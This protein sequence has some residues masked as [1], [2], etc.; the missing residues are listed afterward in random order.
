MSQGSQFGLLAQ[1]RFAP[2]FL[3]QFFGAGNDNAFKFALTVL[4]TYNA[5][6]WGGLDPRLAGA[7][8]GGIFILPFVLFSATAGQLADKYEKSA[9]IRFVKNFEIVVMLAVAAGFVLHI[10][11]L[12]FVGVFLMGLHSTLFG[13]VKYA[14]LPQHLGSDELTGGNGLVETGTFVAILLGTML[15]G[16]LVAVPETGASYV[17]AVSL[18]LAVFG[19]IAA[20]FVPHSAAPD[21]Q[22][23][24]NWNPLRETRDNLRLARVNRTVFLSMLGISWLWFFGSIFLTSFSG[25]AKTV[26]GGD[27]AVVTMLLAVFS[28]GIGTGSLL[29]ERLSGRMVEIGLVPFGA[30]GMTVFAADLYFATNGDA[31]GAALIG[32]SAMLAQPHHWRML[33]DLFLLAMFGGFYSVP[34]YALIQSRCEPHHRARIIAANK[35]LN[36]LFMVVAS[37][38]AA[39]LLAAGLSLPQLFLVTALLNALVAAY[40]FK[41]VPEF[42]MRFAAWLL[43]HSVYRLDKRG[44]EH[45]PAEGACVVVCNHVSFADPVVLLGASPRP[46]RFVMDHRIFKLPLINFIFRTSRAIPIAPAK[47]DAAMMEC[48]F[49]EVAAALRNGEVVGI[50]PEGRITDTGALYPFRPGITRILDTTP[51]PVV[52][53]A[54]GGLWDSFFSRQ[55]GAAMRDFRRLRPFRRV[56]LRVDAPLAAAEATPERLQQQVARM[57]DTD[58]AGGAR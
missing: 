22:L 14:Y 17:A 43:I 50:F 54:L 38:M 40:I 56:S 25:L 23:V 31:P 30:I 42:L 41:L 34:L 13:P 27:E 2:F 57:L 28:L 15:G 55:G 47:E 29:C 37:V 18:L 4:A 39:G 11:W 16:V 32:L 12:P 26:L 44:L 36:A 46:I 10:V 7:V 52:P 24:I 8:I 5:A 19:R 48:A 49:A 9:L 45:I 51:V 1:R 21:P 53:M 3:T 6:E 20:G 33:A 35:I 58:E